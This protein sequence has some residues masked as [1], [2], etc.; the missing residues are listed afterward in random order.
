MRA[1]APTATREPETK[2]T[3][4]A[5]PEKGER[6]DRSKR[7]VIRFFR[8]CTATI[9]MGST[10]SQACTFESKRYPKART[11]EL[12]LMEHALAKHS[13]GGQKRVVVERREVDA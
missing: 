1:T 6:V 4:V 9:V 5:K 8:K 2:P 13:E 12:E 7:P 3:D 11:A 10:G